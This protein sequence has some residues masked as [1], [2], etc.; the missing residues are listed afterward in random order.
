MHRENLIDFEGCSWAGQIKVIRC[1]KLCCQ[2]VSGTLRSTIIN[3]N[4]CIYVHVHMYSAVVLYPYWGFFF[5]TRLSPKVLIIGE[6]PLD[7][8]EV[9]E[10]IAQKAL[11]CSLFYDKQVMWPLLHYAMSGCCSPGGRDGRPPTHIHV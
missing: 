5:L 9:C 8:H 10:L 11:P 6:K 3:E 7:K 2:S 4:V 1:S